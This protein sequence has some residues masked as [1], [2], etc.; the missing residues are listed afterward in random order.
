[1]GGNAMAWGEDSG[2]ALDQLLPMFEAINMS[3]SHYFLFII[4]ALT[5]VEQSAN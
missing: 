4:Q 1:M 3:V 2:H 5:L